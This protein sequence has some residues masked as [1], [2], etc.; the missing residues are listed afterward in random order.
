MERAVE[1]STIMQ[2]RFAPVREV[3]LDDPGS[4]FGGPPADGDPTS[5]R[6]T[7]ELGLDLG[8]RTSVSQTVIVHLGI[9]RG[10]DA[11]IVVPV[12]WQASG[13]EQLL[14][15]FD[16]E[17]A[18]AAVDEGTRLRLTGTYTVPLGIVG[19]FGDGVFGRRVARRSL[20]SLVQRL[21]TRV[22]S[23]VHDRLGRAGWRG[24]P[25]A[26]D[27]REQSHLGIDAG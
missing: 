26:V 15:T 9:A 16:G 5:R 3:L 27:L 4:L 10:D 14:P 18:V 19:R 13:H 20:E 7:M 2:V 6:F 24:Q 1:A 22:E 11:T 25:H 23:A 8:A 17:V 12:R 21:A